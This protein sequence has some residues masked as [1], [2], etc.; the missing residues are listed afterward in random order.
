MPPHLL[1]CQGLAVED[2]SL[3]HGRL[4]AG[5]PSTFAQLGLNLLTLFVHLK[6]NLV[7]PVMLSESFSKGFRI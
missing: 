7:Y 4:E 3:A 1:R 2:Y 6:Q 5:A